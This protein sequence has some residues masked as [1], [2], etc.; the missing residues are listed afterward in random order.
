MTTPTPGKTAASQQGRTPQPL[1]ASPPVS[2]PFSLTGAQVFSP[3]G[4][5]RS[6]PQQV[7]KSPANST[8]L[9]GHASSGPLNFDSPTAAAAMG[10]LGMAGG[11]DMGLDGVGVGGLAGYGLGVLGG[12]D[13]RL[14]RLDSVINILSHKKGYVSDEGLERLVQRIGFDC[15]WD[16]HT[17]PD[18]RKMK[19][20]VVAGKALQL[21][22][23]LDNNIVRNVAMSF[24][25]S[26]DAVKDRAARATAILLRDLELR[27]GQSPLTKK[28]D[29]FYANLERLGDL[30]KHSV[31]PGFD[32]QEAL[33]G[34]CASLERIHAY[35]LEKLRAEPEVAGKGERYVRNVATC[36]RH[37][38][39]VMHARDR[40]GL[41][42]DYWIQRHCVPPA[43]E[44]L[45]K[46]IE[47]SEGVWS[48]LI[49]CAP[50][51]DT[52]YSPVRIS[53]DW[54]SPRIEKEEPS[55]EDV[56]STAAGPALDWLEPE[57]TVLPPPEEEE[58][59]NK[60]PVGVDGG[61]PGKYPEVIFKAILDPPVVLPQPLWL[62]M[63]EL[64]GAQPPPPYSYPTFDS[65]FFPIPASDEAHDPSAP[66]TIEHAREVSVVPRAAR[67]GGAAATTTTGARRH[68]NT[69]YVYKPVYGQVLSELPFSHPKQLIAL[70]PSLRQYALLSTLLKRSFGD[71][72]AEGE[73]EREGRGG[74]AGGTGT[75]MSTVPKARE[76]KTFWSGRDADKPGL[77]GAEAMDVDA[78]AEEDEGVSSVDVTLTVH[79][80]P[81]LQI[82]FPLRS[83]TANVGLEI[84]PSGRVRITSQNI[85]PEGEV[86]GEK[87]G[88]TVE[89]LGRAL[90]VLEDIDQWCE[91][92]RTRVDGS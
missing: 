70:L 30:D 39:P 24:P 59:G 74:A 21:E 6:S 13:E 33:A 77:P 46:H 45:E 82:V 28:L 44:R 47:T 26:A 14:K 12:E 52:I 54:I 27:P 84:G 17:A 22:I 87:K 50:M 41:S 81:R 73:K 7:R 9:A 32:L 55:A 1:A 92:I 4:G 56:L 10:S 18:G 62:H 31:I 75:N 11:L 61:I 20:L 63:Y 8:T 57:S 88:L 36:H 34:I 19:M 60:G 42:V 78:P 67:D 37:G 86:A 76:L 3:H 85:L 69:L 23:S 53:E 48:L 83:S 89:K 71:G 25:L 15:L 40:V 72:S 90:E 79:P 80:A 68:R 66:R 91:W 38:Y 65:L 29:D 64:V 58:G 43:D 35:D 5:P 16:T 51:G 49:T 2:T